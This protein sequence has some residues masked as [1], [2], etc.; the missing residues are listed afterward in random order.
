MKKILLSIALAL[1]GYGAQAQWLYYVTNLTTGN[2]GSTN[3]VITT[4]RWYISEITASTGA[5]GATALYL[6]DSDNGR[7]T[8]Y[9]G[10]YTNVI[11]TNMFVTN[12]MTSSTGIG[13]TNIDSG[14]YYT[15]VAVAAALTVSPRIFTISLPASTTTT[16]AVDL[17]TVH[18]LAFTNTLTNITITIKYRSWN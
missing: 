16:R 9:V 7:F 3:G 4:N 13:V 17:V 8:N 2:T 10:A 18:G 15:N 5:G 6:Y 14:I 11:A 1:F 12:I